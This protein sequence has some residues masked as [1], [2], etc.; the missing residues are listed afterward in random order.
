VRDAVLAVGVPWHLLAPLPQGAPRVSFGGAPRAPLRV[1]PAATL[2]SLR[3]SYF[4][5]L[6]DGAAWF[7]GVVHLPPKC[8]IRAFLLEEPRNGNKIQDASPERSF[9]KDEVFNCKLAS[10][11][12]TAPTLGA[13][14]ALSLL[15]SGRMRD[16]EL[17]CSPKSRA[18]FVQHM[19]AIRSICRE[20]SWEP[21]YHYTNPTLAPLIRKTGFRMSTQGQG[22]GGRV[23]VFSSFLFLFLF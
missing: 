9:L 23:C 15:P 1:L 11:A 12:G 8:I 5:A 4:G 21:V 17:V 7:Q 13:N 6:A 18:E 14:R 20:K 2:S 10:C 19:A 16:L 22:G 3:G